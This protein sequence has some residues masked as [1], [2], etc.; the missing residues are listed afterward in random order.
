[1]CV[2]GACAPSGVGG[3]TGGGAGG[4]AGGGSGSWQDELVAAHNQV[5]ANASPAPNP[6]LPPLTWNAQ[7]AATAQAWANNC[8]FAH[9]QAIVGTY[10]ENL[11]ASTG[12]ATPTQVT[13]DWASERASYNYANNTCSAM[14][15]HYTQIVWR[16]TTSV[17][18]AS[19]QCTA[20]NPFGGTGPW[21]F[22]VCDYAPP[23]NFVR[24]KPY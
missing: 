3:G 14:C 6:P 17:G 12:S 9:N 4:G 7:A 21:F 19:A 13:N 11:F 18:C 1:M 20:N 22:W 2:D 23:G 24:M 8:R 5:R 16:S 10:G 15:G